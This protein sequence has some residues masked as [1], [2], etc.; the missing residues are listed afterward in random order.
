[1]LRKIFILPVLIYQYSIS[2]LFP[3]T[4][5]FQPTCSNYAKDAILKHGI[6]KGTWLGIKRISKCH[7]WGGHG[8][9]PVP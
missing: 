3:S 9:D 5:R 1:L 6:F 7:P 2:P 8:Y 4:C